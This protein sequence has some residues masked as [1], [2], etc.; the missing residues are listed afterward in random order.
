M[1][2]SD[3]P[4]SVAYGAGLGA[5]INVSDHHSIVMIP[6]NIPV[7]GGARID[8]FVDLNTALTNTADVEVYIAY[9]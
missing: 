6:V 3:Y 8:T 5:L 7:I 1:P 9:R 4:R 2:P